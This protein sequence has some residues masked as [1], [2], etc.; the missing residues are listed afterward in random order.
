[1]NKEYVPMGKVLL[2]GNSK[3][4][5]IAMEGITPG[6]IKNHELNSLEAA[7]DFLNR[8]LVSLVTEAQYHIT[9]CQTALAGLNDEQTEFR[10]KC[11]IYPRLQIYKSAGRAFRIEWAKFILYKKKGAQGIGKTTVRIPAEK[12]R[13]PISKFNEAP[14]WALKIILEYENKFVVI[15]QK[16]QIY[17]DAKRQVESLIRLYN[18]DLESKN[19]STDPVNSLELFQLKSPNLID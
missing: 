10:K 19:Y 7:N 11:M 5:K 2:A 12:I 13:Y 8:Y 1:M 15:R 4:R 17:K 16:Y 9:S 14:T 18:V 3:D 6:A